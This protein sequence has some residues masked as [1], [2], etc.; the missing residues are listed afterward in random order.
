MLMS[1]PGDPLVELRL[2]IATMNEKFEGRFN[3][4]SEK[5][6]TTNKSLQSLIHHLE[7]KAEKDEVDRKTRDALLRSNRRWLIGTF[8]ATAGVAASI[9]AVFLKM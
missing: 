6:E 5:W 1:T 4:M 9:L 7:S 3:L 8:V 2:Q